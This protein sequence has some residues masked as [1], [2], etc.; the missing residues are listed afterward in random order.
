MNDSKRR[1]RFDLD[2]KKGSSVEDLKKH[3]SIKDSKKHAKHAKES[4]HK[5]SKKNDAKVDRKMA[6]AL[7]K[8]S[9]EIAGGSRG[10]KTQ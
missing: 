6:K 9:L 7:M 5:K 8:L 2:S 10:K 3:D 4:Q 1:V